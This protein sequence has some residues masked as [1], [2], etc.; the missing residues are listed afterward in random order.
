M[1]KH[2]GPAWWLLYALAPLMGGL[3]VP[4]RGMENDRCSLN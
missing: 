3:L 1:A 2:N 4:E